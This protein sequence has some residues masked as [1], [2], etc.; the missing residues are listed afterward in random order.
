MARDPM[1]DKQM[2]ELAGAAFKDMDISEAQATKEAE[3]AKRAWREYAHNM[4]IAEQVRFLG[5]ATPHCGV[6]D[7]ARETLKRVTITIDP[8]IPLSGSEWA[9]TEAARVDVHLHNHSR[10]ELRNAILKLVLTGPAVILPI[11]GSRSKYH[12]T[13]LNPY[14]SRNLRLIVKGTQQ[15]GGHVAIKTSFCAEVVPYACAPQVTWED[16]IGP[17]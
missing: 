8:A 14:E 12:F 7:C 16:M 6:G 10:C 9:G 1:T 4:Q 2:L 11:M 5:V 15:G 3:A 17:D 13:K